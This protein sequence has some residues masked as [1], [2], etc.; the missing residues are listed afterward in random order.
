MVLWVLAVLAA[1]GAVAAQETKT[2]EVP[3][4]FEGPGAGYSDAPCSG[5]DV[6][7]G[8]GGL[9]LHPFFEYYLDNNFEYSPN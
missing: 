9:R 2:P 6:Q 1:A 5:P 4:L 8:E 7:K 3:S